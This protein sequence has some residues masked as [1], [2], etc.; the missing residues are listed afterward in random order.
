[1][2]DRKENQV[3]QNCEI[4]G[5]EMKKRTKHTGD[6]AGVPFWVCARYPE[7]RNVIK[8]EMPEEQK[9]VHVN[10][11]AGNRP[12]K[13]N[14]MDQE[15]RPYARVAVFFGS[16]VLL[17]LIVVGSLNINLTRII[18]GEIGA[19]TAETSQMDVAPEQPRPIQPDQDMAPVRNVEQAQPVSNHS[20]AIYTFTDESGT[21]SM[22]D[23]KEKV[24]S[25]YRATM[26]VSTVDAIAK[27]LYATRGMKVPIRSLWENSQAAF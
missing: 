22:V 7:C 10:I 12:I 19:S 16:A 17:A 23:D 9:P 20:G 18:F 2:E 8:C 13:L 4:C 14:N 6:H 25:R 24:P 15:E 1:M 27:T 3:T 26:K 21:L 11:T 5:S